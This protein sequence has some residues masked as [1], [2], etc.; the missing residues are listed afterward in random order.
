MIQDGT[1]PRP[2]DS[3]VYRPSDR[4]GGRFPHMWLDFARKKS[5]LDWF[6]K[7]FTLVTG[8]LGQE[9]LEAG[10]QAAATLR[11]PIGLQ[12]MPT[13]DESA[14]FRMGMRGAVLVRP[15]GHVAWR[16][17]YLPADAAG[18]IVKVMNTLLHPG[19]V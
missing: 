10:K 7:T 3:R 15:D 18:E 17:P 13:V 12:T 4:P 16:M 14:G 9:W 2:L 6:D 8:P 1:V 19:K 5:T 11:L